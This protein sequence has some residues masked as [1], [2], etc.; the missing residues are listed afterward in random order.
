MGFEHGETGRVF[1]FV[2]YK[3]LSNLKVICQNQ[4]STPLTYFPPP[5]PT[6]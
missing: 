4:P 5:Y 2:G 1:Y 3:I 6:P